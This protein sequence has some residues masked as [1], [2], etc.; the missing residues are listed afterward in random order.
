MKAEARSSHGRTPRVVLLMLGVLLVGYAISDHAFYGGEPGFGR[1][2]GLISTAGVGIA[3]CAALPRRFAE[4]ILLIVVSSL[5]MLAFAEIAGEF[6][7]A[8][9]HRPIYQADDKLIFKLIPNR[10][11]VMTRSRENGGETVTHRIN[12]DGFRGEEF[13]PPGKAP[14][15][16]VYGDSFIHAP[17]MADRETFSAVLGELLSARIG[18]EV[19]VINAGV[20]SYGPDQVSAKMEIELPRLR[21]DLAIVAIFAGNDYGD[22]MRNKM[23]KID[24][25]DK[26][27]DNPWRLDPA[28][29]NRF[30]LSQRQS[31]LLRSLR[32]TLGSS[33]LSGARA[34]SVTA[35][36]EVSQLSDWSFLLRQS[37]SEYQDYVLGGNNDVTNTHVDYYSADMSL[38]PDGES[39]RYKSR[40]MQA[41][42]S[43]IRDIAAKS[44]VPLVFVFIPHPVDVAIRYDDWGAVDLERYPHYA[45]RNQTAPLEAGAKAAGIPFISLYDAYRAVDANT[46]YFHHSDDHWNAA[47]QRMAAELVSNQAANHLLN[48]RGVLGDRAR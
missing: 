41:V 5:V 35:R 2:Q 32:T 16:V 3:T 14:R 33:R 4:R 26:L 34:T 39:A 24:P 17:Y 45:G 6:I 19:E 44:G 48:R 11:S 10:R 20:S 30:D 47:G 9:R 8:P 29:R 23:I 31:I 21:P 28:V 7:L 13:M 40:M 1:L 36:T 25:N 12:S 43:R 15:V 38:L 46:L 42:L 22:L 18:S 27:L 37:E